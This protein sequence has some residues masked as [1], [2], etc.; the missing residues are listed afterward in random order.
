MQDAIVA[1]S[2]ARE[3]LRDRQ[4]GL[5]PAVAAARG[6]PETRALAERLFSGSAKR[7]LAIDGRRARAMLS[8][9]VLAVLE[10]ELR[11]RSGNASTVLADY[12]D[13]IG[14]CSLS[15]TIAGGLALGWD[16]TS[17]AEM[18]RDVLQAA[19]KES[20]F[21]LPPF[22]SRYS[23]ARKRE[24]LAKYFPDC[25]IGAPE[26]RTGLVILAQRADDGLALA[27][28]QQP[29]ATARRRRRSSLIARRAAREH[30]RCVLRRARRRS[31][32]RCHRVRRCRPLSWPLARPAT[33]HLLH[34]AAIP[35]VMAPGC[36]SAHALLGRSGLAPPLFD[37][38]RAT[39][40]ASHLAPVMGAGGAI[41]PCARVQCR[42]A[43]D[44]RIVDQA[45]V[46]S[47]GHRRRRWGSEAGR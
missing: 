39:A 23:T 15:S 19:L 41:R 37:S 38:E 16:V 24:A 31:A 7:I 42:P 2:P 13:L 32:V 20:W 17:V 27:F 47:R 18:Y 46:A 29:P 1:R 43:A 11:K 12:F 22:T 45:V 4:A 3:Y 14:S 9:G 40:A 10:D 25:R 6:N 5:A 36:R 35:A 44:P 8:L 28:Q 26:L 21:Y 30:S 33:S 34:H